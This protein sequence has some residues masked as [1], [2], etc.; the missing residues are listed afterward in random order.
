MAQDKFD[1]IIESIEDLTSAV[2]DLDNRIT[3][4][5]AVDSYNLIASF[6]EEQLR[7]AQALERIATALEKQ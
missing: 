7:I 4:D 3:M 1:R 5:F 6:Y 2:S